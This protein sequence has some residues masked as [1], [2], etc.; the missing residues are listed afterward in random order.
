MKQ[1]KSDKGRGSILIQLS[2][3]DCNNKQSGSAIT[4]TKVNDQGEG[5]QREE[6]NH[7]LIQET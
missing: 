1:G 2:L 4:P 7:V 3:D 5:I 6:Q